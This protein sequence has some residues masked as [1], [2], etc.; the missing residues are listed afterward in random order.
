MIRSFVTFI[1]IFFSVGGA[2]NDI[3]TSAIVTVKV[4]DVTIAQRPSD[5]ERKKMKN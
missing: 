2:A 3:A 1:L 5:N 4:K